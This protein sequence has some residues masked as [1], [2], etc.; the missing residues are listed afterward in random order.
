MRDSRYKL[1]GLMLITT[2]VA[3][4]SWIL[5]AGGV[6][7]TQS[8]S[9]QAFGA[10]L[11][12]LRAQYLAKVDAKALSTIRYDTL[13]SADSF[14]KVGLHTGRAAMKNTNDTG[15]EDEIKVGSEKK[16]SST[17][18]GEWPYRIVTVNIYREGDTIPRYTLDIP[19]VR[20]A[21]TYSKEEADALVKKIKDEADAILKQIKKG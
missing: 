6:F 18:N 2:V 15:W 13:G 8:N 11:M 12:Q 10:G 17:S 21:E 4:A 20:Q 5:L 1:K 16:M 7:L 14:T 19:F 3:V 9:F